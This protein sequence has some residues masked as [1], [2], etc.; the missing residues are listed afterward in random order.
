MET[1]MEKNMLSLKVLGETVSLLCSKTG[2]GLKQYISR[3][4]GCVCFQKTDRFKTDYSIILY[5]LL[6]SFKTFILYP[7]GKHVAIN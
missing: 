1:D 5:F 2:A 6:N 3:V 7:V 4:V